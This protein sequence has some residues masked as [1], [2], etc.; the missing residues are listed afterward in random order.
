MRPMTLCALALVL[1]AP[2]APVAQAATPKTTTVIANGVA[3][4]TADVDGFK[5]DFKATK[6]GSKVGG[7]FSGT[8]QG[9]SSG[10]ATP[11]VFTITGP[12]TC[13]Q[14]VGRTQA[15]I[16]Y[17]VSKVTSQGQAFTQGEPLSILLTVV[18]GLNGAPNKVGFMG[19]LPTQAFMGSC[20][21]GM[22]PLNLEGTV[23]IS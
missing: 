4:P 15:G 21:P 13:L 18:K 23:R 7:T 14:V 9:G 19:P 22:A 12:V 11:E 5:I 3:G 8:L 10:F 20:A 1:A 17:P 2:L 16:L 6:K